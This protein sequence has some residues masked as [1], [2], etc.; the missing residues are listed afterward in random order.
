LHNGDAI[1]VF[2]DYGSVEAE[3][4][5]DNDLRPGVVA[6]SHGYGNSKAYSLRVASDKA[7][8][9]CNI[10][11]P[12]GAEYEPMSHMSWLSGVPVNVKRIA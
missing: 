12:I 1:R 5:I 7:G 10:L 6:M 2:N 9:N 8:V 3:V 11:M 4:E